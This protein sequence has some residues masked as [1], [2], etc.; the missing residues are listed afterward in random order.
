MSENYDY[1]II[2]AGI[3]GLAI[4]RE[5][6]R[7]RA[8]TIVVLEKEEGLGQH[9]SGRNSGVI[10]AGLYY[11]ADSSKARLCIRGGRLL[12]EY[13]EQ[14][15]LSLHKIGKVIV[16]TNTRELQSLERLYNQAR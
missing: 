1:A 2:G 16:A 15:R 14:Y 5:L 7:R 10:H 13:A 6:I 9:A 11:A 3:I 4:A 8:G 12:R